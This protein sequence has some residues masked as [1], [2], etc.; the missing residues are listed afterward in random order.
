M[1]NRSHP[2]CLGANGK[3]ALKVG[4]R[5]GKYHLMKCLGTGGCCVVW[6][7]RDTVENTV[8]A[9]KIPLLGEDEQR[10]CDQL[11]REI[12][13]VSN[14]RQSRWPVSRRESTTSMI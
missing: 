13:L 10:R 3:Q 9:L 6:R 4:L 8:V 2:Q 7:A 11:Y 5:L 12:Q 14:S 1:D